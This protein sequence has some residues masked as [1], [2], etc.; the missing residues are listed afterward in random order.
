MMPDREKVIQRIESQIAVCKEIESDWISLTV[1]QGR[2]ILELLNEE[3]ESDYE[4]GFHDGYEQAMKDV[5]RHEMPQV[6][7]ESPD[8]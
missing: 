2:R 5:K 3:A 8:I 6:R 4:N 7:R 1:G